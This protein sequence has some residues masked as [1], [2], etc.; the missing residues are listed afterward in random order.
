MSAGNA[1]QSLNSFEG[2][3]SNMRSS[4][5]Q[6]DYLLHQFDSLD[7]TRLCHDLSKHIEKY[8]E[9]TCQFQAYGSAVTG[10]GK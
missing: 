10:L 3:M 4:S 1:K 5:N 8:V 6:L 2:I 9:P 7:T